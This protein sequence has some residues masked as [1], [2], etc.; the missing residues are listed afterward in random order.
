M[1]TREYRYARNGRNS[2]IRANRGTK[3]EDRRNKGTKDKQGNGWKDYQAIWRSIP[4]D[5]HLQR[6]AFSAFLHD[7]RY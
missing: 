3:R 2:T 4:E 7:A 6:D 5:G 1:N